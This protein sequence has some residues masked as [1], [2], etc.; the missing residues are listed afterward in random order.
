MLKFKKLIVVNVLVLGLIGAVGLPGSASA[1]SGSSEPF[2]TWNRTSLDP[3]SSY[4]LKDLAKS[5]S[6]GLT[7][8][9]ATGAC[10][11][12]GTQLTT[13]KAGICQV[14]LTVK[15]DKTFSA[16]KTSYG[17][18]VCPTKMK[19]GKPSGKSVQIGLLQPTTGASAQ[20]AKNVVALIEM[21]TKRVNKAGGVNCGELKVKA[22]DTALIPATA[23][24]ETQRAISDGAKALIGPWSTSEALASGQVAEGAG[25]VQINMSA[26]T[27]SITEDK[28]FIF[29]TSPLTT[30]LGKAMVDVAIAMKA[31]TIGILHDSGGFGLG[32]K[33]VV[34]AAAKKLGV[35]FTT[36]QYTISATSVSS[37]VQAIV[38]TKPDMVVILGSTGADYGLIAKALA[39]QN[40]LKPLV[41]FSPIVL[42]D[43]INISGGAYDKLPGI[44]TLQAADSTKPLYK[45]IL[46]RFNAANPKNKLTNL[47]EQMLG[48]YDA[49]HYLVEGLIQSKGA[50]GK[51]LATSLV[52][53]PG[54][55]R[56]NGKSGAIHQF[57]LGKHDSLSGQKY[58]NLYKLVNGTVVQD[59]SIVLK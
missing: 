22:Y 48:A 14:V 47:P 34:E 6:T 58:L 38:N 12:K 41:G 45:S 8:W 26:A 19:N 36:V 55:A 3:N 53:L 25:V 39:E 57:A 46:D 56:A 20:S 9:G 40:T 51:P 29:R 59:T 42:P 28:E 18:T 16:S 4:A 35:K 23:A 43:A 50:G 7:T 5:S 52:N 17:L 37:E 49:F 31:S 30:D 27:N 13:A 11:V 15:G 33:P 2:V 32:A 54:S 21:E 44:Y 24:L 1:A 10:A